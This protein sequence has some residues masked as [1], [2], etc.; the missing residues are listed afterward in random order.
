M[1]NAAAG[2]WSAWSD[3]MASW[4]TAKAPV[5]SHC[6]FN[7]TPRSAALGAYSACPELFAS[8]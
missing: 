5:R 1:L 3:S 4:K 7:G 6:S 8:R 2:A